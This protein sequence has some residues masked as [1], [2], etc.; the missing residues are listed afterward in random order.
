MGW[1]RMDDGF[2]DHPKVVA[3]LDGDDPLAAGAA[4]GLWTLC[5]TWAHRNTR[6]P[7]KTPGLLPAGLPRRFLGAVGK[8]VAQLL[9]K[10]G[11]WEPHDSG[12]WLIHDFADFLPTEE[13]RAARAEAGR[14][15]AAK[16][17]ANRKPFDAVADESQGDG[18]LPSVCH[19][20]ASNAEANDGSRAPARRAI[21]KE[22]APSPI[23]KPGSSLAADRLPDDDQAVLDGMPTPP[24][25]PP[26]A[27]RANDVVSAFVDASRAAGLDDPTSGIINKVA[28]DAKRLLDK[29][30]VD[31]AKLLTAAQIMGENGYQSL[32][33]QL[34]RM[35]AER[36]QQGRRNGSLHTVDGRRNGEPDLPR[37]PADERMAD[38]LKLAKRFAEED[39]T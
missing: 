39:G 4:V 3:L 32:D 23:P 28:R 8:D 10:H 31:P 17:W 7:R 27:V 12:G 1:G 26:P 2:D 33:V 22:I 24:Q 5:W 18:N 14:R 11:L 13:T 30:K 37:S 29:D 25:D 38:A 6:K 21:S 36:A 34:R 19:D 35:D 9:V 20:A 15:G 16:R